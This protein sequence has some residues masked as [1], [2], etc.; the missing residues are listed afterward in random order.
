MFYDYLI[1]YTTSIGC[2]KRWEIVGLKVKSCGLV[3]IVNLF[4][5]AEK[6]V[7]FL[8]Y[9]GEAREST[10]NLVQNIF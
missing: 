9:N 3:I 1:I 2:K 7:I 10:L 8:I 5:N 6:F 4:L